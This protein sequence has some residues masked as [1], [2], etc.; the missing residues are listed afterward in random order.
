M[1]KLLARQAML[2]TCWDEGDN[3]KALRHLNPPATKILEKGF[4]SNHTMEAKGCVKL[5]RLLE[6]I[7]CK[8]LQ[9]ASLC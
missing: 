6:N 2:Y 3:E 7:V 5:W 9:V 1:E 8:P 4:G